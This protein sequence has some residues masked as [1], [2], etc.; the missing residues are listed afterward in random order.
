[1]KKHWKAIILKPSIIKVSL[2]GA[3]PM[4]YKIVESDAFQVVGIKREFPLVNGGNLGI[5]KL[6]DEANENGTVDLLFEL[7]NGPMKGVL[8][9]CDDSSQSEQVMDYWIATAYNGEV[10]A[11]LFNLQIPASQWAVFEVHGPMPE[12]M[13]KVWKQIFSEWFPS[14][15]YK[16][17]GTPG[18][19]VYTDVN[20]SNPD[21]YSE[22]WIPVK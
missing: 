18:L 8:G 16:H 5:S 19:E 4:K 10:P 3:K 21:F 22:I 12:A 15:E 6:W 7:N 20:P 2:K 13:Q 11:E 9:V 17:A 14:S 1:M